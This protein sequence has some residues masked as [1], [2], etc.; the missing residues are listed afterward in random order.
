MDTTME[1][2]QCMGGNGIMKIYPVERFFRDAKHGQIA[3][4]TTEI[5]KLLIYRQGKRILK[6]D[7]K[8]PPRIVDPEIKL[9]LPLGKSPAK[10]LAIK[11]EDV[12][13]VLTENYRTN[14][15]LH[16]TLEDIQEW[17]DVSREN[18][19]VHLENLEK[20]GLS[21]LYRTKDGVALARATLKGIQVARPPDYYP[22]HS[23]M[24]RSK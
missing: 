19:I 8:V 20:K 22:L 15:G 10:N 5:L 13:N 3:A 4:G 21:G 12:L 11:D 23:G 18:L 9:P 16:M 1:A 2:I 7:L 6:D 17:L 24:G 14:P